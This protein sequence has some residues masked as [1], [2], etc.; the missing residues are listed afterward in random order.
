VFA[1]QSIIS[2]FLYFFECDTVNCI[3]KKV[4]FSYPVVL[5]L[6]SVIFMLIFVNIVFRAFIVIA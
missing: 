3:N 2:L 6:I 4:S 5:S 1:P